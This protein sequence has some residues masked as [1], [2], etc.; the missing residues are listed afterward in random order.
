MA[1]RTY[2][3][4]I[5]LGN[6][7]IEQRNDYKQALLRGQLGF[8]LGVICL[9]YL[10][11]D[12]INEIYRFIPWYVAGI[13]SSVIIII[14]NRQGKGVWA[15]TFIVL[16]GNLITFMVADASIPGRGT[17]FLFIATAASALVLF[18]KLRPSVGLL[19]VAV[20]FLLGVVAY[21]NPSPVLGSVPNIESASTENLNF[22]TN[23]FL[24]LFASVLVILFMI[25]RN[26]ESEASITK[27]KIKV[28]QLADQLTKKNKELE[29]TN[30]E[31]DRFVYSASHDMRAPLATLQGLINVAKVSG[32]PEDYP[33]FFEL[34]SKRIDDLEGF[35]KDVTDYSRNARQ[36]LNLQHINLYNLVDNIVKNFAFLA[37][38]NGVKINLEIPPDLTIL[39]DKQRLTVVF[40]NLLANAIK[41]YNPNIADRFVTITAHQQG[42]SC[43]VVFKDNGLGIDLQYADKIF[44]MFYRATEESTGSGLGLYIV[45]ETLDRLGGY[46]TFVSESLKGSEFK[47]TLPELPSN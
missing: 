18:Y 43:Q 3:Q 31:L 11:I 17:F 16:F 39:T 27:E 4:K 19:F 36:Q 23:F 46:V 34:M 2:F 1:K 30:N 12:P 40:N 15:S 32:K 14:L 22:L 26:T 9:T 47:V 7:Y 6:T 41:Y 33:L 21:F 10:I 5:L 28:E 20:S 42:K 24:G 8:L 37:T 29:K 38:K 25:K 35:I 13:V 44:D 45:K